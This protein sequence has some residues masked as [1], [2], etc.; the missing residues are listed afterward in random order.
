[1]RPP[2]GS[3]SD[4]ELA[5]TCTVAFPFCHVHLGGQKPCEQGYPSS[6]TTVGEHIRKVR[7]DRGLLQ[8]EA[9]NQ[10]GAD[11]KTVANWEA[12]RSEPAIWHWPGVLRMLGFIPFEIGETIPE[13]LR[14]YRMIRG[15]SQ[16]DLATEVGVDESTIQGWETGA[17]APSPALRPRFD[18]LIDDLERA[19][20]AGTP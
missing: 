3:L 15:I 2:A 1:M 5:P 19:V 18:E 12:G 17:Q 13:R 9:A 8:R 10:I 7:M 11:P 14:A 16:A 6:P 20:T 4:R